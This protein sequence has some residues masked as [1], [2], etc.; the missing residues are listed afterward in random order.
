MTQAVWGPGPHAGKPITV[1]C[2][3]CGEGPVQEFDEGL[4]MAAHDRLREMI[5]PR[6]HT[7][8][9]SPDLFHM[10][11]PWSNWGVWDAFKLPAICD[12]KLPPNSIIVEF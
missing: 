4:A 11:I 12:P 1:R 10:R 7:I 3:S 5:T 8:R 6:S 2:Q 9:L